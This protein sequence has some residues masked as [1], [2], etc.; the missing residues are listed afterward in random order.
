MIATTRTSLPRQLRFWALHCSV[1]ALPSFLIA[2]VWIG[3]WQ[4]PV[5]IAAMLAAVATFIAGYTLTCL[6]AAP[7]R[8][9]RSLVARALGI[10]LGIRCWISGLSLLAIV[11][12]PLVTVMPDFWCGY[13]AALAVERFGTLTGLTAFGDLVDARRVNFVTVYATTLVEGL[14]L[15]IMLSMFSFFALVVVQALERR[16]MY[17]VSVPP[18]VRE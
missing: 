7:L 8:D 14:I 5:A 6:V 2:L 3:L 12:S 10:G 17:T 16:K 11:Y 18:V 4:H 9:P 13:A 15:S 1:N